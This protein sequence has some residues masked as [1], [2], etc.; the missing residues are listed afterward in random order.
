MAQPQGSHQRMINNIHIKNIMKLHHT[1]SIGI[2]AI[3]LLS[4]TLASAQS[5]DRSSYPLQGKHQFTLTGGTLFGSDKMEDYNIGTIEYSYW[6][7]D[8]WAFTVSSA[9]I[10]TDDRRYCRDDDGVAAIRLGAQY[11]P[12]FFNLSD[13]VF[14]TAQASVG[15]YIGVNHLDCGSVHGKGSNCRKCCKEET[16]NKWG[17]YLGLNLNVVVTKNFLVSASVG[18]HFVQK[19]DK[20]VN[21]ERDFSSPDFRVGFSLIF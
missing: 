16:E 9:G 18:N 13:R 20:P 19:F 21:G 14:F 4:G 8:N 11:R 5:G 1:L 2:A 17:A 3:G 6:A 12:D 7:T 15:Q 10:A